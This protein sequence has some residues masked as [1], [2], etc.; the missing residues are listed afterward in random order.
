LFDIIS[1]NLGCVAERAH[2]S[3]VASK[4][5]NGELLIDKDDEEDF[6]RF[7]IYLSHEGP[8]IRKNSRYWFLNQIFQKSSENNEQSQEPSIIESIEKIK[9][10]NP[11]IEQRQLDLLNEFSE[12]FKQMKWY[13]GLP[14]AAPAIPSL[15]MLAIETDLINIF[16]TFD[17]NKDNQLDVTELHQG[18]VQYADDLKR[19]D[20]RWLIDRYQAE[21]RKPVKNKN[22][23]DAAPKE[24]NVARVGVGEFL[25]LF[26]ALLQEIG[27][28]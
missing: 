12:Q 7:S 10:F 18:A 28:K 22:I 4:F 14:Y 27:Y 8:M 5:G 20:A 1:K 23:E 3:L 9:N 16:N 19:R 11:T 13:T 25:P 21:D 15:R 2:Y 26:R 6:K 24:S 17:L